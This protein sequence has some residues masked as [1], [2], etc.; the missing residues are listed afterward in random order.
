M[1][2]PESISIAKIEKIMLKGHSFDGI[3]YLDGKWTRCGLIEVEAF[4]CNLT[5]L[6]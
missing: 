6:V 4:L 2:V 1:V 5:Q 3:S